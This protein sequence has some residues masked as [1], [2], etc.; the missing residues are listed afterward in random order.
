MTNKLG[1][2]LG[3]RLT[4][5]DLRFQENIIL[6]PLTVIKH[7]RHALQHKVGVP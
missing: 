1:Q 7:L 3:H 6:N 2:T 4:T 5:G